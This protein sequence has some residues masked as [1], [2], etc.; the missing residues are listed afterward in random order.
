MAT[1]A[2]V[3][4]RIADE[5]NRDDLTTQIDTAISDAIDHYAD[6]N[7][8]F[9]EE[10]ETTVTVAAQNYVNVPTGLQKESGVWLTVGG[11]DYDLKKI[12]I[13]RMED[14][15]NSSS[16]EGQ[17]VYYAYLDG[18]F[19]LWPTPNTV[20]TLV[21]IGVFDTSALSADGDTNAFTLSGAGTRAIIG[22]S[23]EH[24]ASNVTYDPEMEA[25]GLKARL[26]AEI[27]LRRKANAKQ[28]TGR[29][30]PCL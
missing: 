4:A 27:D 9:N 25:A 16:S 3:R 6:F 1:Y 13:E 14:L 29:L 18:T 23:K 17:P 30:R 5:M 2:D 11:S 20:Y 19:R 7:F 10:R 21:I 15:T 12:S 28:S 8:A 26:N 24:L 22:W